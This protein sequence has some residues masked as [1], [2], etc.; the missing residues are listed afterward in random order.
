MKNLKYIA[1]TFRFLK[2]STTS[3]KTNTNNGD[4]V[5]LT[6]NK[7]GFNFKRA[8]SLRKSKSSLLSLLYSEEN[9]TLFI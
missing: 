4:N 1:D 6:N 9:N 8:P 3:S 7:L 2:G 5:E